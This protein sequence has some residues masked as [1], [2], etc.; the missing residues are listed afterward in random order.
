MLKKLNWTILCHF[1][2]QKE[3]KKRNKSGTHEENGPSLLLT[4]AG[5][6]QEQGDM[7]ESPAVNHVEEMPQDT[8]VEP[9][10]NGKV[11]YFVLWLERNGLENCK[12][13]P[14]FHW[15]LV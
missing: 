5:D 10:S 14:A 9:T 2:L 7:E 1:F 6:G 13:N 3:K 4:P 15:K 11:R 12:D 8:P